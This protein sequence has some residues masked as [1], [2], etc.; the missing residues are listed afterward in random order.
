MDAEDQETLFTLL[1]KVHLAENDVVRPQHL[2]IILLS[3]DSVRDLFEHHSL[4]CVPEVEIANN[5]TDDD[6]HHYVAGKLQRT[7][8]FCGPS[9]FRDEIVRDVCE[10]AEDE[11]SQDGE[12]APQVQQLNIILSSVT[13]AKKPWLDSWAD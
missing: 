8:L 13:V 5:Q 11:G 4:D 10:Q 7:R 3:R 6:L 2:R 9:D 12:T 1:E